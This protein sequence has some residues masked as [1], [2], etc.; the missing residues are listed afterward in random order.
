MRRDSRGWA[1]KTELFR[2]EP[3]VA[4][5]GDFTKVDMDDSL[6]GKIDDNTSINMGGTEV[7]MEEVNIAEN[8]AALM[9]I[10]KFVFA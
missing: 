3:N 5:M 2:T 7:T 4:A 9:E 8:S 6:C 1:P 10:Q